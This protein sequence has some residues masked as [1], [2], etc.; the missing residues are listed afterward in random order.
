MLGFKFIINLPA[1]IIIGLIT[2]LAYIGISESK[3]S[4]NFMVGLKIVVL[5]FIEC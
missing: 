3:R 5:I 4:A 1:F 2:I